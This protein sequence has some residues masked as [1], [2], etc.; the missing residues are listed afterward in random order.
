MIHAGSQIL[1]SGSF[2][3]GFTPPDYVVDGILQRGFLYSMTSPTGGGKTA[4][5]LRIAAHVALGRTIG[6]REVQPGKCLMLI[7]ENPDDVRARWIGLSEQ[8]GFFPD[9]VEVLFLPQIIPLRKIAA[10]FACRGGTKGTF[11]LG[12]GGHQRGIFSW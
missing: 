7:S 11:Q 12:G 6:T 1:D 5:S 3:T 8:M 9:E 10:I 4:I 2:V